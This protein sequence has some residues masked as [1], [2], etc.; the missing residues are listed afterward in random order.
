MTV[1][2]LPAE[3]INLVFE[4]LADDNDLIL[5]RDPSLKSVARSAALV[6]GDWWHRGMAL[7]WEVV[8]IHFNERRYLELLLRLAEA[9]RLAKFVKVLYLVWAASDDTFDLPVA[10]LI[11]RCLSLR[12]LEMTEPPFAVLE[13]LVQA[14]KGGELV[15]VTG[16]A[17]N[18]TTRQPYEPADLCT[19]L[20]GMP[21]LETLCL[22]GDILDAGEGHLADLRHVAPRAVTLYL[23]SDRLD[24]DDATAFVLLVLGQ[25]R[26]DRLSRIN[27]EFA[28][29]DQSA[30]LRVLALAPRLTNLGL[31]FPS[32]PVFTDALP[33]LIPLLPTFGALEHLSLDTGDF[34]NP[35]HP[36]RRAVAALLD[37]LPPS[38]THLT[39]PFPLEAS[40]PPLAAFLATRAAGPLEN[41]LAR[42]GAEALHESVR[43]WR[44][45]VDCETGKVVWY[46]DMAE[47][48][49]RYE[50]ES[51]ERE[52]EVDARAR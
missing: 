1:P 26:L 46:D 35:P 44:K 2:P 19:I 20:A 43:D 34:R 15:H 25:M 32:D 31:H 51:A 7:L 42:T 14:A 50:R 36:P 22:Q 49:A 8:F 16:L 6:C 37:A 4:E 29:P 47:R 17:L 40:E 10:P 27:L 41:V 30:V 38:L 12:R 45:R 13:E 48:Y 23:Q 3:V 11:E 52:R 18:C 33:F 21:N 28:S 39:L 24:A 5:S 9:P